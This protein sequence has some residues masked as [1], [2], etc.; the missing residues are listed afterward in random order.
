[1]KLLLTLFIAFFTLSTATFAVPM[2]MIAS[3]ADGYGKTA[4]AAKKSALEALSH[5]ILSKVDSTQNVIVTKSGGKSNIQF[6]S[7]TLLQSNLLF[8]GLEFET[9]KKNKDEFKTEVWL[10]HKAVLES[11]TYLEAQIPERL[12]GLSKAELLGVKNYSE[13]IEALLLQPNITEFIIED[14]EARLKR[15][16][17]IKELLSLK[18]GNYGSV[19]IALPKQSGTKI[20]IRSREYNSGEPIFLTPGTYEFK[21][22]KKGFYGIAGKFTLARGQ[23]LYTAIDLVP[24]GG[25]LSTALKL[26]AKELKALSRDIETILLKYD[27]T[28]DAGS[29]N[30]LI[31]DLNIEKNDQPPYLKRKIQMTLSVLE[32]SK[33]SR[34]ISQSKS[35][36]A[37][38]KTL[39]QKQRKTILKLLTK[40]LRKYRAG[41]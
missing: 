18:L 3:Q 9:V 40:L 41:S 20:T 22:S 10:T 31:L 2:G 38:K 15:V 13:M 21:I 6:K 34:S 36:M 30:K 26:Q 29:A 1:M 37:G 24:K 19:H 11:V 23:N 8:K 39:E 4:E 33:V 25:G 12:D 17:E 7:Q 28:V 27:I 16:A 35:F 14:K 5:Q 32:N